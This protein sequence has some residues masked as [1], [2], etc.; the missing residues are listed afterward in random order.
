MVD[1]LLFAL[2]FYVSIIMLT[3]IIETKKTQH[4]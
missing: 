2:V 4:S 1:L 3:S